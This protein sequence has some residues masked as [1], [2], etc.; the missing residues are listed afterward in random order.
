MN[1]EDVDD[2]N[3]NLIHSIY[4]ESTVD[5]VIKNMEC[6]NSEMANDYKNSIMIERCY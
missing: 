2:K 3:L 5:E 4:S 1:S 6:V